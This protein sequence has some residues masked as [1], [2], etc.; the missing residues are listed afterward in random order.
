MSGTFHGPCL[1]DG[2]E[3]KSEREKR[4]G[5]SEN[6]TSLTHCSLPP[7]LPVSHT[8]LSGPYQNIPFGLR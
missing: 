5:G 6:E 1:K 3:E 7:A 4:R 2:E 8:W